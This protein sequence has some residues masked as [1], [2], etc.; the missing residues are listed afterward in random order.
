MYYRDAAAAILIFDKTN[1]ASLDNLKDW[2]DELDSKVD[3][4]KMVIAIVMNKADLP[5][6]V[7]SPEEI[8]ELYE[9]RNFLFFK[10]SAKSGEG[11]HQ[12]FEAV[13]KELYK[14]SLT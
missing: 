2:I 3:M 9:K 8:K 13:A 5:D 10:T 4:N 11:V 1:P 7:I 14:R 6:E 12:L